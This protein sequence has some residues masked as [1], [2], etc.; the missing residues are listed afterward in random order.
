M[1]PQTQQNHRG[2]SIISSLV[3]AFASSACVQTNSGSGS[4]TLYTICNVD[5]RADNTQ[6]SVSLT[7][8]GNSVIG[9][10]VVVIDRTT[11]R[12]LNLEGGQRSDGYRY[13]GVFSG[14]AQIIQ[15]KITSGEDQLEAQLVGPS[16][17]E[18]T[19]PPNDSI[20]RRGSF[21]SLTVDWEADDSADR[22]RIRVDDGNPVTLEE[23][24]FTAD[25][26]ISDIQ[27]GAHV[28]EV[29]R[30][31]EVDLAGGASGSIMRIRYKV[32]NRF[33]IEG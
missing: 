7:N 22:V 9:A 25:I 20:V 6:L 18:L 2:A 13:E 28:I 16:K 19:R 10:N 3:I 27:N 12:S 14:Y 29:E 23:D 17:H 33:T 24:E 21:D 1:T 26:P 5:A 30:E 32:D 31:N 8:R 15:L 4:E 11:E